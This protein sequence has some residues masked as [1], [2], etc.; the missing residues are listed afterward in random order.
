MVFGTQDYTTFGSAMPGRT[1][2]GNYRY[3]FNGKETDAETDLQ[4][5]GMRIYNPE[6]GR[7]L[8]RDPLAAKYPFYSPYLFAG[9]RPIVSIDKNGDHE[10]TVVITPNPTPTNPNAVDVAVRI[11]KYCD[12]PHTF[13]YN[14]N[15]G[16]VVQPPAKLEEHLRVQVDDNS[17][18]QASPTEPDSANPTSH[19]WVNTVPMA[20]QP[21][22]TV[23]TDA[24]TFNYQPPV[25]NPVA[26]P[27]WIMSGYN[28]TDMADQTSVVQGVALLATIGVFNPAPGTTNSNITITLT[29]SPN[30]ANIRDIKTG[31]ENYFK[32]RGL[33]IDVQ[34][35]K[36]PTY[37]ARTSRAIRGSGGVPST[38]DYSV[39]TRYTSVV[40][41]IITETTP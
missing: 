19:M 36:D 34:V 40:K 5:Y 9:D 11:T 3:S 38:T 30:N 12:G 39:G 2:A 1:V 7:F 16:T 21:A 25:T 6:L 10:F 35:I 22:G 33:D 8:S 14:D 24:R 32:V 31:Y 18:W 29:T 13:V 4:D 37:T 28:A 23:F 15:A 17:T 26:D 41:E 20:G 27:G